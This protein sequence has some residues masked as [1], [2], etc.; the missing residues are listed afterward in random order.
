[1]KKSKKHSLTDPVVRDYPIPCVGGVVIYNDSVLLIQRGKEPR[2]GVWS[3][4]GGKIE[5]GETQSE[6]LIREIMEETGVA[7]TVGPLLTTIDLIRDDGIHYVLIDYVC[8]PS[9]QNPIPLAGDDADHALFL[10]IED[11]K[12]RVDWQE[13][14]DLIDQAYAIVSGGT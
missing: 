1:M 5:H 11:A 13:T 8:T 2:K 12:A 3:V 14:A 9:E 10:P 7:V 6:A 4:P